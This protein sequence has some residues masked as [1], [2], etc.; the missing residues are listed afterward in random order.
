MKRFVIGVGDPEGMEVKGVP[1]GI[2]VVGEVVNE[3]NVEGKNVGLAV[4]GNTEGIAV[5]GNTEGIAVVG[6]TEGDAVVGLTV[7]VAV[8]GALDGVAVVGL[9]VG[10]QQEWWNGGEKVKIPWKF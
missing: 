2:A 7:G 4:V 10:N 8:T 5:V 9:T 3:A 6:N 1:D